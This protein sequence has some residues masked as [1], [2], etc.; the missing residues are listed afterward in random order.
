[1]KIIILMT[2]NPALL[3]G[4][5]SEMVFDKN[6]AADSPLSSVDNVL[7]MMIKTYNSVLSLLSLLHIQIY[8]ELV[9]TLQYNVFIALTHGNSALNTHQKQKLL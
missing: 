2:G 8:C 9:I 5:D 4:F 6:S 7:L 3:Y 1:M